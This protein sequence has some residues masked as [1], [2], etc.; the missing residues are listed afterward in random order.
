MVRPAFGHSILS[1]LHIPHI[2]GTL[3]VE[4]IIRRRHSC[5]TWDSSC[6]DRYY[7]FICLARLNSRRHLCSQPQHRTCMYGYCR[8][9]LDMRHNQP[10]SVTLCYPSPPC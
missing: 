9:C 8:Q 3:P 2:L 4:A 7:V 6:S 10:I 1:L 5:T